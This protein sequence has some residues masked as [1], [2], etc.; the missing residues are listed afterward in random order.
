MGQAQYPCLLLFYRNYQC[1]FAVWRDRN[2]FVWE[3]LREDEFSPLK[4]ADQSGEKDTPT[5]A[6]LALFSLHQ[7]QILAAGG[8]FVDEEGIRLPLIPRYGGICFIAIVLLS[9]VRPQLR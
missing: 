8:I 5:T 1:P 4:N 9:V 6:R 7:R 2:F 3:V